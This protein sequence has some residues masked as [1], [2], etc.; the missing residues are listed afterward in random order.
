MSAI[1]NLFTGDHT[2]LADVDFNGVI[3]GRPAESC[4][5]YWEV[6]GR[7][8]EAAQGRGETQASAVFAFLSTLAGFMENFDTPQAPFAPLGVF[9]DQRTGLP[10]DLTP[11][12]VEALKLLAS[13]ASDPA[14]RARLHDV[15][16]T[17]ARKD[18][19][20]GQEAARAY[21]AAG[22]LQDNDDQW[23]YAV[24]SFKRSL[25]LA[26]AFGRNKPLFDEVIQ[27]VEAAAQ[28]AT[29]SKDD[30]RALKLIRL[31]WQMHSGDPKVFA[32]LLASIAAQAEAEGQFRRASKYREHEAEWHLAAGDQAAA[33]A[34][35]LAGA[36]TAVQMAE[37]RATSQDRSALAASTLLVEAIEMLRRASAPKAR[38][39][40]ARQ[41]LAE[42]QLES[43]GEMKTFSI[44]F[45]ISESQE[46]AREHVR[47]ERLREALAKFVLGVP[48]ADPA[49]VRE[50]VLA[51][52]KDNPLSHTIQ[53]AH[54]DAKGRTTVVQEGLLG[55]AKDEAEAA[56]LAEMFT[57]VRIAWAFRVNAFITP[58]RQQ[59]VNDHFPT[60]D[61]LTFLVQTHPF[62]PPGREG[63]FLRGLHA[64]FQG[65]F[66]VAAHLLVPQIENSLRYVL[67]N[68]GVN[69]SIFKS[70]GT[71]PVKILGGLLDLPE[72]AKIFGEEMV[73]ELRG[74]L[75]EK[76]GY[77][78]RNKVAHGFV[79]EAECYGP[80][81]ILV[82]W[83]VVRICLW[84][85]LVEA[86]ATEPSS[87]S[88]PVA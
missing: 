64:G 53:K 41:R 33:Q 83:L 87:P 29:K 74:C 51:L 68:R 3:A 30:Y 44:P 69:V 21:L 77:D 45:D 32:P 78:F 72:T 82:W 34:A 50:E 6:F 15:W 13:R 35:R 1:K 19:T 17:L 2:A 62:V 18:I 73:F 43:I 49:K 36:E 42:L 66:A 80:A 75:I 38:V 28:A 86:S 71:Q 5:V 22:K 70:N 46:K 39:D 20:A 12:D 40:A 47:C 79:S 81:A 61:D 67:E 57:H 59:I 54:V 76:T 52:A 25:Q 26:A 55:V 4:V 58:A 56:F 65:D 10:E 14:L 37:A 27:T 31:L 88:E 23:V 7:E 9:G 60:F 16:W 63:L 85:H 48:L 11:N 8:A 24:T 84:P